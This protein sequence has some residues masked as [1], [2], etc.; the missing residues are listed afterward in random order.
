MSLS[1]AKLFFFFQETY[2]DK[3][4]VPALCNDDEKTKDELPQLDSGAC[5]DSELT[6]LAEHEGEVSHKMLSYK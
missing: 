2:N 5:V 6:E 4:G 1:I 3:C